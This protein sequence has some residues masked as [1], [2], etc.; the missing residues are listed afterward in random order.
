[1]LILIP[2][3][4]YLIYLMS[5][6]QKP[7]TRVGNGDSLFWSGIVINS[8]RIEPSQRHGTCFSPTP[9]RCRTG[10]RKYFQVFLP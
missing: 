2:A 3:S 4:L 9:Q 8:Q 7:P 5:L 6:L 10:T 1:M